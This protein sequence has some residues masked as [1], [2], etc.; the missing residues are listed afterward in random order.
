MASQK[1]A[2]LLEAPVSL[3]ESRLTGQVLV[4]VVTGLQAHAPTKRRP[5]YRLDISVAFG[6][7]GAPAANDVGWLLGSPR[8]SKLRRIYVLLEF[9]PGTIHL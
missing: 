2:I 5:N 7:E 8:S 1:D 6:P 9:E 4:P 3:G